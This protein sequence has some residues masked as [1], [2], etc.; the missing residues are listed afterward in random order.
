MIVIRC[1]EKIRDKNNA[2]IAYILQDI[3]TQERVKVTPEQ[4]KNVML[5]KQ[6]IVTNLKL[7][8]DMRLIECAEE[9]TTAL[10]NNAVNLKTT[11]TNTSIT[12]PS[13]YG[14]SL[15]GLKE[16]TG[17]EGAY[18]TATVYLNNK[19]LGTWEQDPYGAICDNFYF[20]E[21]L[22]KPI[23]DKYISTVD[24]RATLETLMSDLCV[25]NDEFKQYK[26]AKE[27]GFN[28]LFVIT[29]QYDMNV[30][31]LNSKVQSSP[32]LSADIEKYRQEIINKGYIPKLKVYKSEKDFILE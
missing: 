25:L 30:Y 1:L 14:L 6:C 2:I 12:C 16:R 27:K 8:S 9:K 29:D 11:T 4:L 23:L 22:L 18:W 21:K 10:N 32:G 31:M 7:T 13:I 26:K 17:R 20:D 28:Y 19:K 3:R 5:K 15:K 24:N